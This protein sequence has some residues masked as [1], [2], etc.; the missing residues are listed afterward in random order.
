MAEFLLGMNANL[1]YGSEGT[2]IAAC[3]ELTNVTDVTLNLT[4]GEA[5]VT[6]R[7]NSGW[8]ATAATLRECTVDFEMMWK[9]D[10]S[11]FQAIKDAFL[12]NT[13]IRLGV[14][15]GAHDAAG[16]E[17]PVGDFSVTQFNRSEPLA[18]GIKVAVTAKLAIYDEWVEV[19]PGS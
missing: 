1:Y 5:D 9:P 15:T 16:T 7:A 12:A 6:T 18:D 13:Y 4:A 3:T 2:D 19:V 14:L 11:G 10:D 8:K 17:G